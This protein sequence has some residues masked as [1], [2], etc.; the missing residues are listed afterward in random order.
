MEAATVGDEGL[1]G[2]EAFFHVN[3]IAPGES[4][5]QVPDT[6][7]EKMSV[8]AFHREVALHGPFHDLMGQYARVTIAQLMQSSACNAAHNVEERCARW[9]L[10]THDRM[11][12]QDFHLSQEFLAV[13]LGVRRQ[14]VGVVAGTLQRAGLIRYTHGRVTVLDRQGLEAAS[15]ECYHVIRKHFESIGLS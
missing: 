5:L 15:C 13:M 1:I 14:T 9:L 4:L 12:Q 3:A 2:I 11:H 10:Q 8:G 7:A 6:N